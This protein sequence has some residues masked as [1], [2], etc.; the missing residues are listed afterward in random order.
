M[1]GEGGE[2]K[3]AQRPFRIFANISKQPQ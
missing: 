2:E 3:K 1:G